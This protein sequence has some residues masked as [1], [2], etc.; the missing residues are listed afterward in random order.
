MREC[1]LQEL[2]TRMSMNCE[3]SVDDKLK[4]KISSLTRLSHFRLSMR[5]VEVDTALKMPR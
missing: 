4:Y 5:R 2:R 1:Y 3:A